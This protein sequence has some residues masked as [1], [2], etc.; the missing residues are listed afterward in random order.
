V[1]W[2]SRQRDVRLQ[3]HAAGRDSKD[4]GAPGLWCPRHPAASEDRA[5]SDRATAS[6][7][8]AAGLLRRRVN[9]ARNASELH[10]SFLERYSGGYSPCGSGQW[11]GFCGGAE[12]RLRGRAQP[13]ALPGHAAGSAQHPDPSAPDPTPTAPATADHDAMPSMSAVSTAD[14][15]SAASAVSTAD[16]V[17]AVSTADGLSAMSGATAV[18]S[19]DDP[20][21]A[22]M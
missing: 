1:Q 22:S 15:L 9:D 6:E 13:P 17:S 12:G 4:V 8:G 19:A 5:R 3:F 7:G 10:R 14:R 18:D 20:D 11:D 2:S 21:A 16:R